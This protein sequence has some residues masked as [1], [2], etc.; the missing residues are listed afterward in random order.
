MSSSK[1]IAASRANGAKSRGPKTP[2]GKARSSQNAIKHGLLSRTLLVGAESEEGFRDTIADY[3]A[4]F[5]DPDPVEFAIIIE[6]AACYWRLRRLWAVEKEWMDQ[7]LPART[8]NSSAIA[9]IATA[10]GILAETNKFRLL[11]LYEGRI[12]RQYH[13]AFETLLSLR[14]NRNA[15]M[16]REITAVP[17][18]S[19]AAPPAPG[20]LQKGYETNL[21][22]PLESTKLSSGETRECPQDSCHQRPPHPESCRSRLP[23][24]RAGRSPARGGESKGPV[25]AS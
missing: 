16:N 20:A 3:L 14:R 10:F 21:D 1:R 15:E 11:H 17:P 5:P 13:T 22:L 2:A 19:P 9:S 18:D 4:H 6:I 25:A 8:R 12:H 7:S 23:A 24:L